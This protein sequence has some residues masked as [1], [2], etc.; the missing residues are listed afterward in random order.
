[1]TLIIPR[2]IQGACDCCGCPWNMSHGEPNRQQDYCSPPT[3]RDCPCHDVRFST[4]IEE[5]QA[6]D[7]AVAA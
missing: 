5:P 3:L 7:P 4:A 1:M 6:G 2:P